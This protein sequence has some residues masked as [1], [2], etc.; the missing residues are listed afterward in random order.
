MTSQ[1]V[2]SYKNRRR[3]IDTI[4]GTELNSVSID[5]MDGKVPFDLECVRNYGFWCTE[6]ES[7]KDNLRDR[8]ITNYPEAIEEFGKNGIHVIPRFV[9][10]SDS[11]LSEIDGGKY[12]VKEGSKPTRF[13]D[14]NSKV[15]RRYKKDVIL[16]SMEKVK[17]WT[18]KGLGHPL[19]RDTR[20]CKLDF[21]RFPDGYD[22]DKPYNAVNKMIEEIRDA[23]PSDIRL[24][25]C[26]YGCAFHDS[27]EFRREK[28]SNGQIVEDIREIMSRG[29]IFSMMAYSYLYRYYEQRWA[30]V[31][32]HIKK[33]RNAVEKM[34]KGYDIDN[35]LSI[36]GSLGPDVSKEYL[37]AH[38][39][40]HARF[41]QNQISECEGQYHVWNGGIKENT[42]ALHAALFN[43]PESTWAKIEA[44]EEGTN[45]A[46]ELSND[47]IVDRIVTPVQ[48]LD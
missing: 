38:R 37:K 31:G 41:L 23:L 36:Q 2:S 47:L 9:I 29:D 27:E 10:G 46:K 32:A 3:V 14:L 13:V 15:V 17:E 26:L 6:D 44:H 33:E 22:G 40:S 7:K 11:F 43:V 20:I 42:H 25:L 39:V 4:N 30:D 1:S 28:L 19:P 48:G 12:A 5:F 16:E 24:E 34:I 45:L 18:E 35:V 21:I 8:E